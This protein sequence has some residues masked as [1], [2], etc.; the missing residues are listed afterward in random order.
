MEIVES[1]R[2]KEEVFGM[3]AACQQHWRTKLPVG[4][5]KLESHDVS[6]L[7]DSG[8]SGVVVKKSLVPPEQFT[9]QY[10]LF[11]LIDRTVRRFPIAMVNIDSPWF[12]GK[13]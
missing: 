12:V 8:C 1:D 13:V 3:C 4:S 9:G 5:G 10:K 2:H 7:R 11:V 6:V